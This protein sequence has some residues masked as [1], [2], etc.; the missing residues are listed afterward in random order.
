MNRRRAPVYPSSPIGWMLRSMTRSR[1]I[2]IVA[3]VTGGLACGNLLSGPECAP[4]GALAV[5]I[6][7]RDAATGLPLT[8]G[9]TVILSGADHDSVLVTSDRYVG[10]FV[11]GTY[12]VTIRK[13][14]YREFTQNGIVVGR[15]RCDIKTV[16]LSVAL[17]P[18][19]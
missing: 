6:H 7:I 11:T 3:I 2:A 13:T 9:A 4:T 17:Q 5:D 16:S 15:G 19:T 10:G 18:S 8:G 12:S 1:V 14:G